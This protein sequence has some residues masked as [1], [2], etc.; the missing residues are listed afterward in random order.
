MR[1][2]EQQQKLH[3]FVTYS[4]KSMNFLKQNPGFKRAKRNKPETRVLK[5]RPKSDT[6]V[7]AQ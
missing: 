6:L 2:T 3:F 1:Q 5:Y 7:L 4:S